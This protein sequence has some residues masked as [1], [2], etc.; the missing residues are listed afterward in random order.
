MISPRRQAVVALEALT[1]S[2]NA[3]NL[4]ILDLGDGWVITSSGD[5]LVRLRPLTLSEIVQ[6]AAALRR[7]APSR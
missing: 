3:A 2:V 7:L 6:L 5:I 1:D 4:E